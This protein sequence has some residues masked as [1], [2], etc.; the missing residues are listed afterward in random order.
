MSVLQD[1]VPDDPRASPGEE[2]HADVACASTQ[3]GRA[4][5]SSM[6]MD[7]GDV[8]PADAD[9]NPRF[10]QG[11][12][13]VHRARELVRLYAHERD[14]TMPPRLFDAPHQ[15]LGPDAR[16]RLVVARH[17]DLDVGPEHLALRTVHAQAIQHGQRIRR[18]SRL[19]PL[20]HI[21]V[22]VVVRGLDEDQFE[23]AAAMRAG[24]HASGRAPT[25]MTHRGYHLSRPRTA[26][27]LSPAPVN[28]LEGSAGTRRI[29]EGAWSDP[30][31]VFLSA[32]D[33]QCGEHDLGR[34]RHDEEDLSFLPGIGSSTPSRRQTQPRRHHADKPPP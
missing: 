31:F 5:P 19:H 34:S 6:A 1:A 11:S 16:I 29:R 23:S 2:R 25:Q 28:M 20:D 8:E 3:L 10:A 30:G 27:P 13:D 17:D 32:A 33:L 12:T 15:P 9:L 7:A 24:G 14:E 18:H 4:P 22:V 26:R 21:A